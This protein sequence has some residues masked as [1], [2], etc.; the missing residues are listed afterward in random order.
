[1]QGTEIKQCGGSPGGECFLLSSKRSAILIDS[2]FSFSAPKAADNIEKELNGKR[3][4]YILLTHS[5]YDHAGGSGLLRERFPGAKVVAHAHAAKI[6]SKESAKGLMRLLNANAAEK[7]AM[8]VD[9]HSIDVL[10]VDTV[11]EHNDRVKT[12]DLSIRAYE[13]PGHTQCSTSYYIEELDLLCTSESSGVAPNYPEVMPAFMSSYQATLK[14]IEFQEKL[15]ARR[16]HIPHR[17]ILSGADAEAYFAR[18]REAAEEHAE[19]VLEAHRGGCSAEEIV[20]RYCEKYYTDI[21]AMIQ[22]KEAFVINAQ[23]MIPRLL[24]EM[25]AVGRI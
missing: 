14:S 6:F 5:H 16:L 20:N 19:F 8:P 15:K 9:N 21:V 3:L 23:A 4:D 2:G 25:E 13:T 24:Q 18:S 1:M 7:M 12:A 10:H 17:G 22:P 11:V